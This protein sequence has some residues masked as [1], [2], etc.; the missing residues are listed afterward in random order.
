[1]ATEFAE[2]LDENGFDKA[3]LSKK[4]ATFA[5]A[6][7]SERLQRGRAAEHARQRLAQE[8]ERIVSQ[9]IHAKAGAR[10]ICTRGG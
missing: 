6:Y 1:M 9:F 3:N 2:W 8:R 10:R 7:E 4:P 5:E